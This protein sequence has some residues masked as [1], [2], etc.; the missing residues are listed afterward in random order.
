MWDTLGPKGEGSCMT[1]FSIP[2]IQQAAFNLQFRAKSSD[3]PVLVMAHCPLP[4]A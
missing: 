3:L 2:R 4:I 1:H